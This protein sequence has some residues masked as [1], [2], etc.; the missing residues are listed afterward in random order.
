MDG[1]PVTRS[2]LSYAGVVDESPRSL[3]LSVFIILGLVVVVAEPIALL[4]FCTPSALVKLFLYV[5][6]WVS[7]YCITILL[8]RSC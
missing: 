1:L 4:D 7:F 6:E 5:C 3:I 2:S 8:L